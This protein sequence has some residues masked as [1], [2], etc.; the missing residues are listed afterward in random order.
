[1]A[2]ALEDLFAYVD[3]QDDHTFKVTLSFLEVYETKTCSSYCTWLIIVVLSTACRYNENLRDLL[4]P[5]SDHLSLRE[6]P[7]KVRYFPP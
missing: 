6:D 1:M 4:K 7:V 5:S 2:L 3:N